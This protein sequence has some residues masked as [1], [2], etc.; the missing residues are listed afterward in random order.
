[1]LA[2][3]LE[4]LFSLASEGAPIPLSYERFARRDTDGIGTD[5]LGL[6]FILFVETTFP[7]LSVL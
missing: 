4:I 1:M 7:T 2:V 3:G 6:T 5:R